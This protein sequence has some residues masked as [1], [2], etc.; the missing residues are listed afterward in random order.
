MDESSNR[1]NLRQEEIDLAKDVQRNLSYNVLG[2]N[3][4]FEDQSYVIVFSDKI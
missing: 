1:S 3:N 2:D 4:N